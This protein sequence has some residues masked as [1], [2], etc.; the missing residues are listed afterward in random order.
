VEEMLEGPVEVRTCKETIGIGFKEREGMFRM[1]R[2][3]HDKLVEQEG[4]YLFLVHFNSGRTL[5][6]LIQA[7]N[8]KFR[9]NIPW[10]TI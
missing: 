5:I 3:T 7:K 6:E 4:S 1:D 9:R 10:S 8:V 2:G